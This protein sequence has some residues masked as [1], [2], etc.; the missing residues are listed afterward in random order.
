M[1]NQD[2]RSSTLKPFLMEALLA[3][4]LWLKSVL[5]RITLTQ[6]L[7]VVFLLVLLV[8]GVYHS[9]IAWSYIICTKLKRQS[10]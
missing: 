7:N 5:I 2:F 9:I 4:T 1:E 8:A 3:K 10:H 6:I